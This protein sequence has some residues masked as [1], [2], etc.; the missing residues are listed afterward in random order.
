MK[1]RHFFIGSS[2]ALL[3]AGCVDLESAAFGGG[4][5]DDDIDE[6]GDDEDD[7]LFEDEELEEFWNMLIASEVEVLD[8]EREGNGFHLE[9][10]TSGNVDTDVNR[11]ASAFSSVA[12]AVDGDLTVR[13]EDRGLTE[14][15]FEIQH[16]WAL[17]H[18]NGSIS[19]EE[20]MAA[21]L[22]TLE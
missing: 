15:T 4:D 2:I 17:D 14:G 22:D 18:A 10:Q 19:D 3:T 21:I 9:M 5:N 7:D 6:G 8:L 20:Y 16:E 1:R 13:I 12:T 11:V